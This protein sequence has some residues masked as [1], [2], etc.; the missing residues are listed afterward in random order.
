MQNMKRRIG[1]YLLLAVLVFCGRA[2]AELSANLKTRKEINRGN[3]KIASETYVDADGNPVIASDKGYATIR[4]TYGLNDLVIRTELLDTEGKLING[5]DGYARIERKYREKKISQQSYYDADGKP[6]T[7]PEGYA[8]MEVTEAY[9]KY[10]K[11][12]E[13]GPDGKPV[14]THQITLYYEGKKIKSDSWYDVNN[15]LTAGPNGY[16]RM[17]AEYV[18]KTQSKVAYYDAEGNPFFYAKAGYARMERE[19]NKT[20]ETAIRYYGVNGEMIPGPDGYAYALYSYYPNEHKRVMYYNADG[21][22][23]FTKK[24]ICG[25]EQ[26]RSVMLKKVTEEYYFIGENQRGKSTDGY[27]GVIR[28]YT[29]YKKLVF[30]QYLDENNKPMIVEKLGY[31]RIKNTIT[32]KR[33][34]RMRTENRY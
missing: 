13:Y 16:A 5:N 9:G 15:N 1:V 33:N 3:K 26:V 29:Q 28:K 2:G 27:S 18:S 17:E 8:R 11:V 34:I 4:Y 20:R 23:Y 6:V 10:R 21:T 25:I 7:G 19:F 31:S 32:N 24:G 14:N 30:E 22:L 12:W